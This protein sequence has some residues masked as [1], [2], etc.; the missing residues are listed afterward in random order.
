[1]TAESD[2][3]PRTWTLDVDPTCIDFYVGLSDEPRSL[4]A[5]EAQLMV[6]LVDSWR[7]LEQHQ[8]HGAH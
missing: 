7:L 1:M 2:D 6:D 8:A 3:D 5:T 4:T